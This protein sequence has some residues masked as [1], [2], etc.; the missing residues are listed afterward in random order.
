LR[1]AFLASIFIAH[2]VFFLGSFVDD[3]WITLRYAVNL[4]EHQQFAY[5][6]GDPVEGFSCPIWLLHVVTLA[7]LFTDPYLVA[8]CVSILYGL[9]TVLLTMWISRQCLRSTGSATFM[10]ALWLVL[11]TPFAYWSSTAME[12]AQY[13]FF[14]LLSYT[15]LDR[16]TTHPEP[17]PWHWMLLAFAWLSSIWSRPEAV[18]Y[19]ILTCPLA[20]LLY[21][22]LRRRLLL[23]TALVS[24]PTVMVFVLRKWHFGLWFPNTVYAKTGSSLQHV[25]LSHGL[26]YCWRF[27]AGG[28]DFPLAH[29]TSAALCCLLVVGVIT[30]LRQRR[31]AFVLPLVLTIPFVLHVRGDYMPNYRLLAPVAPFAA[32]LLAVSIDKLR[33][34]LAQPAVRRLTLAAVSTVLA[35]AAVVGGL[36][37]QAIDIYQNPQWRAKC[38]PSLGKEIRRNICNPPA[39]DLTHVTYLLLDHVPF[40][41]TVWMADIGQPGYA[42]PIRVWDEAGLVTRATS[43]SRFSGNG[44]ADVIADGLKQ[45]PAAILVMERL[46]D[47]AVGWNE[48]Q[49]QLLL[50]PELRTSYDLAVRTVYAHQ[51]SYLM[52]LYKRRDLGV[53]Q[54]PAT[55][56]LGNYRFAQGRFPRCRQLRMR[57]EALDYDL[58]HGSRPVGLRLQTDAPW[59]RYDVW[60]FNANLWVVSA[61]FAGGADQ[62]FLPLAVVPNATYFVKV[63]DLNGVVLFFGNRQGA[64][65]IMGRP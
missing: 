27:V 11:F 6:L 2:A 33:S 61:H 65:W 17:K 57:T 56:M 16:A 3:D 29:V 58:N 53:S 48:L 23:W 49:H 46:A 9:L 63:T 45:R 51:P 59:V 47:G 12:T 60:D 30:N 26:G 32:I 55:Q 7:A 52:R 18:F 54:L 15:V 1:V 50:T 64:E 5:N 37:D 14:L 8:K 41:E 43:N 38:L 13:T 39:A 21:P 35:L 24:V 28:C 36:A 10:S 25:P 62:L 34:T 22:S 4:L 40:G 20:L 42:C 31:V 44:L 19:F